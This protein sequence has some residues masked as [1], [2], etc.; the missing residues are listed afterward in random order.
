MKQAVAHAHEL[1]AE[2]ER[3][4]GALKEKLEEIAEPDYRPSSH[5]RSI[6]TRSSNP[7]AHHH[8]LS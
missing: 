8:G 1:I 3:L 7:P 6:D 2:I 5:R 4:L